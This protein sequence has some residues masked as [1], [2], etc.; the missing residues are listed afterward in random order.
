MAMENV[1]IMLLNSR[2][3][4]LLGKTGKDFISIKKLLTIKKIRMLGGDE[5]TPSL[6]LGK[7]A[8]SILSDIS[9]YTKGRS[10]YIGRNITTDKAVLNIINSKPVNLSSLNRSLPFNGDI[11]ITAV[12]S[13]LESGD[14]TVR[15]IGINKQPV[16]IPVKSSLQVIEE[17]V[18]VMIEAGKVSAVAAEDV[19]VSA[20][21]TDEQTFKSAFDEIRGER[22]SV[23]I[24]V[25][26]DK[27]H[28][29]K[30]KFNTVITKLRSD[31][32]IELYVGDPSTMRDQDVRKCYTDRFGT[33]YLSLTWADL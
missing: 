15:C 31:L 3:D 13:L 29:K 4:S 12:N 14:I 6:E 11:I 8:E 33:L 7:L 1:D 5:K 27:L 19:T 17:P 2:L 25:L 16:F 22:E 20:S 32:A 26:F 18:V 9:V 23:R 24:N 10:T 28:W 21:L 30:E